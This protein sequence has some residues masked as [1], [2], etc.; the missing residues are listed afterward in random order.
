MAIKACIFDWAGTTV[1]FGSF[2]P[3]RAFLE[4]FGE[5]GIVP[6]IE[7]T[8]A[9]M[10][11][12]KI[13]HIQTMLGMERLKRKW[14]M[15]YGRV[16]S[17]RD[18]ESIHA[19]FEAHL[20]VDLER[21]SIPIDDVVETVRRL[22]DRGLNIGSTTGYTGKMM[23]IVSR[24]AKAGGYCPDYLSTAEIAGAGRPSPAMILDNMAYFGVDHPA[25]VIKVGDTLSDIQEGLNAGVWSIGVIRGSSIL[26]L[27]EEEYLRRKDDNAIERTRARYLEAHADFVVED[28][29]RLPELIDEIN[30]MREDGAKPYGSKL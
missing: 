2:A 17:Q 1:D 29:S 14:V 27:S 24:A 3:I 5:H 7:E 12:L 19:S 10:G 11:M 23:E 21:L 26:G 28:I 15:E 20:P 22:R 4:A 8:R 9:P 18:A 6:T 25:D 13:E 16:P 30:A